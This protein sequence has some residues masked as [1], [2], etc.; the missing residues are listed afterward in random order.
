MYIKSNQVNNQHSQVGGQNF[1]RMNVKEKVCL[2]PI[3]GI[4]VY[5]VSTAYQTTM[6]QYNLLRGQKV[7]QLRSL[8]QLTWLLAQ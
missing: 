8:S 7:W 1:A 5:I 3:S 4:E 2:I 6:L